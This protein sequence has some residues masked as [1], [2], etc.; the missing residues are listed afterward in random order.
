MYSID[1][2]EA[3]PKT[4]VDVVPLGKGKRILVFLADLFLCFV[5]A[6]VLLNA[7]IMPIAQSSTNFSSKSKSY[8][9]SLSLSHTILYKNKVLLS[10]Y[11][12]DEDDINSNILYTFNCWLSYYISDAEETPDPSYPQY[13]HKVDNIVIHHYFV[14]IRLN[15][16]NYVDLFNHYNKANE[17]FEYGSGDFQL[18]ESIKSTLS[19]YYNPMVEAGGNEKKIA[20]N[21]K[22]SVFLPLLAEVFTDIKKNDLTYNNNSYNQC[23]KIINNYA[24][25]LKTLLTITIFIA[26]VLSIIIMHLIIPLINKNR[27]TISMMMMRVERINISRLYICKRKESLG[28][29]FYSLFTNAMFIFILPVSFVNFAYIFNLN[30][31]IIFALLSLLLSLS[32]LLVILFNYYNRALSDIFS[33]SILITTAKLDEIYRA[34]GYKI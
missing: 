20:N 10:Y 16:Q 9:E 1:K 13:G 21:I 28:T 24:T 2:E 14:D 17:Y 3:A 18:K 5:A 4:V 23:Q 6:F 19:S 7:M 34:R 15:E 8:N 27:K 26:Y 31:I 30:V 32:S 33:R 11:N 22:N 29:F 25:Y 12:N